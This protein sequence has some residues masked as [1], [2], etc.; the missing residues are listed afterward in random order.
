MRLLD[1]LAV[2]VLLYWLFALVSALPGLKLLRP[3]P[4]SAGIGTDNPLVSVIIAAKEEE[5]SIAETVRHLLAQDY[6][7]MEIIAVNDRS[8]DGTGKRLDELKRWSEQRPSTRIPLRIVHVTTLPDGWLGKNHALYQGY[9]QA[10]GK[11]LLFTDADVRFGTTTI[12]DS[13]DYIRSSGADHL[14]LAPMMIANGFWLR[15]FV[16]Y[17]MFSLFLFLRLWRANDDLQHDFGTGIGAFNLIGRKAYEAIGTHRA[18]PMRPDDDLRLGLLIKKARFK[19]RL[20]IGKHHLEVEWYPNLREAVKGLEK[21]MFSGFGYRLPMAIGGIVGQVL[22]FFGPFA[23]LLLLPRLSGFACAISAV[24]MIGLYVAS[25]RR[26][27]RHS[28]SDAFALPVSVWILVLVLS[29]SV[30]LTIRRGGIY[31]RGTFYPL[32]RLRDK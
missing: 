1:A 15:A 12:R 16:Q 20:L 5:S 6:P 17:F 3:L 28:G 24:I 7:R 10:K 30:Y 21:N 29:R 8:Q 13:V 11:Y 2:L 26:L 31:W 18:F 25:T 32:S 23:G 27:S 22:A 9:L 14:T 19:Q 4:R